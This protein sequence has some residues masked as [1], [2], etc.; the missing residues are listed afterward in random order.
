MPVAPLAE[1]DQRIA[2]ETWLVV[3]EER[4]Y[5]AAG[6]RDHSWRVLTEPSF[7]GSQIACVEAANGD[8]EGEIHSLNLDVASH[9]PW[10]AIP[11][12]AKQIVV[13]RRAKPWSFWMSLT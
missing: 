2:G 1:V 12:W 8:S 6:E 5:S 3:V 9:W 11:N 10:G 7:V 4:L 13:C